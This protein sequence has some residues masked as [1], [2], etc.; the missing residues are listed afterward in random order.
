MNT[1]RDKKNRH[2]A[3]VSGK[4]LCKNMQ[5]PHKKGVRLPA[6]F[7]TNPP[8]ALKLS[9]FCWRNFHHW[10]E[11]VQHPL[12]N[13]LAHS[14]PRPG[15]S[16]ATKMLR[17]GVFHGTRTA[18]AMRSRNRRYSPARRRFRAYMGCSTSIISFSSA[19]RQTFSKPCCIIKP[20]SMRN[21]RTCGRPALPSSH[22]RPNYA[23]AKRMS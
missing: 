17:A 20:T 22:A 11:S 6:F 12:S 1:V 9:L 3:S 16:M 14:L 7:V 18:G 23:S 15:R 10:S 19:R 13:R 21:R 5:H 4:I 8:A 2:S